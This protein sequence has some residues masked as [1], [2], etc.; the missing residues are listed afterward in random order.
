[1]IRRM[2]IDVTAP[3]VVGVI[4]FLVLVAGLVFVRQVG[5]FRPHAKSDD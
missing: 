1:M 4:V 5:S 2:Q 3:I